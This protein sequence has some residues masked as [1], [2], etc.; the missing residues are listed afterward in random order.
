MFGWATSVLVVWLVG[1]AVLCLFLYGVG[2]HESERRSDVS[3]RNPEIGDA[4]RPGSQRGE[5]G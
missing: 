5:T 2:E 4:G 1:A 3:N